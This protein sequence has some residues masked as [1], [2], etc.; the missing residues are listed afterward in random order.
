MNQ[1][2]NPP[3]TSPGDSG[4][5]PQALKFAFW[6]MILVHILPVTFLVLCYYS[7]LGHPLAIIGLILFLIL[8][9]TSARHWWKKTTK[10]HEEHLRRLNRR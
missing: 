5:I 6:W 4:T 3:F 7:A 1:T 2:L 10:Q 9:A 8:F